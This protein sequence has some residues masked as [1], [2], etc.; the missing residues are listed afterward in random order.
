MAK[1]SI[2]PRMAAILA[3]ASGLVPAASILDQELSIPSLDTSSDIEP[4]PIEKI[5]LVNL[6]EDSID[7]R[8]KLLS[9][10]SRTTLHKCPRKYQL[11][12]LSSQEL[13]L[14]EIKELEQGVTFAY[15]TVVGVGVQSVLEGKT[16]AQVILDTFL[17][18]DVD[19]LD[20]TPRQNKSFWLALFAVQRF[21]SLKEDGFLEEYELVY[22][23]PDTAIIE[24][25]LPAVELGFQINLPN[26]FKY[27]GFVD[28]VLKHKTTGEIMV[29]ECKTSSGTAQP[30]TFKNS[31]QALGYSVVLDILFPSLS[32]YTVM[33]LVYET[34]S[35]DYK[36]L[37]FQKSLLQ[38][39]LWLQELLID[40]QLVE[41]YDSYDVYP[42]HGES[43][44]DFFRECE[45]LS[46]CT[47][48]TE[49]LVKPLDSGMLER[50]AK[51]EE[52]YDFIIDFNDLVD[53]Q[54]EKGTEGV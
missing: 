14:E 39:A 33:Y 51:E 44:F 47:L 48:S 8:L 40:T 18:W 15:G 36:E 34:K 17:S 43:C 1:Q 9:H 5:S 7:P 46:L 20:N 4:K 2:S 41:T 11:Y 53:A 52:R 13:A 32:S 30:A 45:Y 37:P 28:A 38:R 49:N 23:S 54:L 25:D 27:R 10:S 22:Y 16:E 35:Y 29:L 42:M 19:L 21:I 50:I 26:G 3:K 31:G 6:A 12:R 24:V